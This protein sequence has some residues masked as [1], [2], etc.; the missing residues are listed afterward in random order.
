MTSS[1]DSEDFIILVFRGKI[2]VLWV[3]KIGSA[4]VM[5]VSVFDSVTG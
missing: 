3:Y 4:L 1:F 5:K 2:D